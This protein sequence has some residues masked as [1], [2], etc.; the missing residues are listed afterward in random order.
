[1]SS[2][3]SPNDPSVLP[4]ANPGNDED[5]EPP[6]KEITQADY[7]SGKQFLVNKDYAQ[8]ANAFHNALISFEQSG[9]NEGIANAN[10]KLGDACLARDDFAKALAHFEKSMEICVK[11]DDPMSIRS[12]TK[13]IALCNRGLKDYDAALEIYL[14]L[15]DEYMKQ[16]NPQSSVETLQKLAEIYQEKGD[17]AK[18]VDSYKTAASIHTNFGHKNYAKKLMDKAEALEK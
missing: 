5:S 10:D 17:I 1:M 18:A 9:N 3:L 7:I 11:L 6:P 12:L 2:S 16:T 4:M 8:A 15:L 14:D 13:K